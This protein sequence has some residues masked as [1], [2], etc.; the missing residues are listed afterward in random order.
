VAFVVTDPDVEGLGIM[1]AD[2]VRGNIEADPTRARLLHGLRGR[3]NVHAVDAEVDVGLEF[4]GGQMLVHAN[5]YE[6]ADLDITCDAETLMGMSSTP[7][8]MGM[9]DLAKPEGRAV[10]GKMLRGELKVKGMYAKPKLMTRLQRLLS[11]E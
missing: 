11:V 6:K 3:V 1:L 9:P 5:P 2:L 10:I 7:L 8:R 4:R